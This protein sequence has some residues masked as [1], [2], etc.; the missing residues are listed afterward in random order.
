MLNGASFAANAPLAPG[1]FA[2]VFGKN[3]GSTDQLTGFP[4]TTFGNVSVT[5]NGIKAPL[6]ALIASANQINLVA[7]SELPNSGPVNVQVTVGSATS[8]NFAV[9]MAAAAPGVF[10][11]LS[12]RTPHNAMRRCCSPIRRG[13]Y[14]R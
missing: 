10:A 13:G 7:P 1:T 14:C 6:Y 12:R 2:S 9:S 3:F 11:V 4:A 5:F 8:A